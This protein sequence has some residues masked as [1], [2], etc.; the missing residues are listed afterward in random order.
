MSWNEILVVL[1]G[2]AGGYMIVIRVMENERGRSGSQ[3]RWGRSS[4]GSAGN[5]QPDDSNIPAN[6]FRILEVPETATREQIV[7]AYQKMIRQYH[8]DRVAQMGPEIR[9]VAERKSKAINAAYDYA[10]KYR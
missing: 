8:P 5:T 7:S 2:L 6:W 1:V 10:I 3:K 4:S 9:E